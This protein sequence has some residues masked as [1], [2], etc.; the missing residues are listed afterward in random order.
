VHPKA[1]KSCTGGWCTIHAG[2]FVMGSPNSEPCREPQSY[3]KETQHQVTL[4]HDFVISET[5]VTQ[6]Q[7]KALVGSNPSWSTT[8]GTDCPVEQV[9]WHDAANYCNL[10]SKSKALAPC[11]GCVTSKGAVT[12]KPAASYAGTK[13]YT[14]PGYR[15]PTEAEWEYAARAGTTTAFHSGPYVAKGC[16]SQT[17]SNLDLIGW[18][19]MNASQMLHKVGQKQPNGWGLRDMSGN[20]WEWCHD[21]WQD[22]LGATDRTDPVV[23]NT[24]GKVVLRS[25]SALE[26]AP[27]LRSAARIGDLPTTVHNLTGLRCVRS[28]P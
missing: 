16:Q 11:Y 20:V 2:C 3:G 23:T 6:A 28:L 8:C 21:D 24:S 27:M 14:C 18:Y 15:L 19:K 26:W 12:C 17:D 25:G 5:E 10:L 22:D 9:T 13:I 4:T 1:S 7:Y